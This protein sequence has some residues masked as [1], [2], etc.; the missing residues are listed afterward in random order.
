MGEPRDPNIY[1]PGDELRDKPGFK[2]QR[3]RVGDAAGSTRLGA[4]VWHVEPGNVF[5]PYH[6]HYVE[7]ELLIVLEGTPRLRTPA[8]WRRLERGAVVSFPA[9]ETG[10]HQLVNDTDADVRLISIS[11]SGE[12]D[13]VSYPDEQKI[14]VFERPP[15][16]GK[17]WKFFHVDADVDY[18]DG[19]EPPQL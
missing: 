3:A 16:P 11:T 12:P 15:R 10:G 1:A 5:Y 4:S 9:G 17:L 2:A 18:W 13:I 19:I 7:E 6:F 14:G 8:G